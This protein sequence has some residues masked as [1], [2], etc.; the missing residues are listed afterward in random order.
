MTASTDGTA[1]LWDTASGRP[2]ATLQG[3]EGA[4]F[5]TTFSP[6]GG[7][8]VTTGVDG[9]ARLWRCGVCRPAEALIADMLRR[10]GREL[11]DEERAQFGLP[12]ESSAVA[13]PAM[14][15]RAPERGQ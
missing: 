6:D 12:A 9:T 8:V 4:A 7:M 2:L 5:Y 13:E 10:V 15:P 1:R 14:K 3:H 11:S